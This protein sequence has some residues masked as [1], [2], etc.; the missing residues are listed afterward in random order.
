LIRAQQPTR[1]GGGRGGKSKIFSPRKKK[2]FRSSKGK[3]KKGQVG[4]CFEVHGLFR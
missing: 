2:R 1:E 3:E 4:V